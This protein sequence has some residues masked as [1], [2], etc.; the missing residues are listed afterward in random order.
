MLLA[1]ANPIGDALN[2][3]EWAFPMLECFHIVAFAF[4]IG[5]IALVDLRLLGF[6]MKRQTAAGLAKD[7]AIWTLS[8][9][10]VVILSGVLI[11]M[12]DPVMYLYNKSFRFK[13]T[14]LILAIIFNYTIHRKAVSVD[15]PPAT[16]KLVAVISLLLWISVVAGGLFIAFV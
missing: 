7:V 5:T 6:G 12:S 1:S 14:A 2:N 3:T 4:S 10:T 9:L 8:G 15:P 13:I 11:F 16:G